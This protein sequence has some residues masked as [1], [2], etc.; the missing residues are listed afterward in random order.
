MKNRRFYFL[1]TLLFLTGSLHAQDAVKEAANKIAQNFLAG[2]VGYSNIDG[3]DYVSFAAQ[4]DIGIGKFG[5]GLNLNLRVNTKTSQIYMA[6]WDDNAWRKVL[7]YVRYGKKNDDFLYF[8]IG[9]LPNATLGKGILVY[10]YNNSASFDDRTLGA[11]FDL[12]LKYFGFETLYADMNE[13]GLIGGRVYLRPFQMTGMATIPIIGMAEFGAGYVQDRHIDAKNLSSTYDNSL[14]KQGAI[15]TAN[16]ATAYSWDIV[17]PLLNFDSFK[18]DT[19]LE[20][21]KF[22]N[23][24]QGQNI[25]FSIQSDIAGIITWDT[26]VERRW[27]SAKYINS[28]YNSLYERERWAAATS[29]Q[30]GAGKLAQLEN[31]PSGL[32]TFGELKMVFG[33]VFEIIGAYQKS[34]NRGDGLLHLETGLPESFTGPFTFY[35]SY[36]RSGIEKDS[37]AFKL[38]EDSL[39]A[40]NVGYRPVPYMEVAMRYLWTFKTVNGKLTTQNRVE[41]SFRMILA[42]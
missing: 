30:A 7:N 33:G 9:R 16:D 20:S 15:T 19:Y 26:R 28:Y 5:F 35:A 1:V 40:A 34:D 39:A 38:D 31:A 14:G 11:V 42:F 29:E 23:Y 10:H 37:E 17:F 18:V 25:G 13:P 27:Q 3:E 12:D 32:G 8:Q 4:P 24:G 21:A 2:G 6:D 41:P 22:V 36:D